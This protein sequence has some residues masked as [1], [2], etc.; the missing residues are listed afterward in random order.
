[1][2]SR[3]CKRTW[4]A[5]LAVAVGLLLLCLSAAPAIAHTDLTSVTPADQAQ[6]EQVPR[7]LVLEFSDEMNPRLSTVTLQVD[8][9]PARRLDVT[10]GRSDSTLIATVPEG[11]VGNPGEISRF[12]LAFRVVSA[13]GHPVAGQSAFRARATGDPNDDRVASGAS[14]DESV[15]QEAAPASEGD[16]PGTAT[17]WALIA[18]PV[19][20]LALLV[21]AVLAAMRLLK[22]DR[23]A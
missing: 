6:L 22:P 18:L 17:P 7:E 15:E 16:D 10:S 2:G 21:I 4:R 19:G 8:S 1:M 13:D 14:P 5:G 3:L 11:V 9:D 12:R 23:D 20:V